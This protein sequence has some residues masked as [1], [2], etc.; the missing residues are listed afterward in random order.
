MITLNDIMVASADQVVKMC[1]RCLGMTRTF[2]TL[3]MKNGSVYVETISIDSEGIALTELYRATH[4]KAT[5]LTLL[6][7]RRIGG[8]HNVMRSYPRDSEYPI[9]SKVRVRNATN[10]TN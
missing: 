6:G 7:R 9:H 2:A 1:S 8:A 5:F 4:K 10:V 3:E